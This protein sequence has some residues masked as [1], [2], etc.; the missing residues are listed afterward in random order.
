M[1]MKTYARHVAR[2]MMTTPPINKLAGLVATP[3]VEG[4]FTTGVLGTQRNQEQLP[5]FIARHASPPR[6]SHF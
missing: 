2:Y 3:T 4:G 5:S 1:K 6:H